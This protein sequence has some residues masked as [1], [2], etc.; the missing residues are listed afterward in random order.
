MASTSTRLVPPEKETLLAETQE[1]L[2]LV[3]QDCVEIIRKMQATGKNCSVNELTWTTHLVAK[4]FF[5]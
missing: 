4:T 2:D 1:V 5:N 3:T